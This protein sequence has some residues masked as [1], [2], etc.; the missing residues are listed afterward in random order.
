MEKLIFYTNSYDDIIESMSVISGCSVNSIKTWLKQS[1]PF[2]NTSE[3]DI[4]LNSFFKKI[5]IKFTGN[6]ELYEIIK[7]NSCVISH[8]TTRIRQPD[9]LD[10]YCLIKA[11]SMPTDISNFLASKGLIFKKTAQGLATYYENKIV[12][13][14]DYDNYSTARIKVRLRVKDK[15]IDNCING[16]LFND[17]IWKDSNVRHIKDCPEIVS[18]ICE[19]LKI[20]E[21]VHEWNNI[22]K[23]YVV[24]FLAEVKDI[25]FDKT[26]LKTTKSKIYLIYKYAI[27]YLVQCYHGIWNPIFDNQMVRLHDNCSVDKKSI[28]GFYE[29]EG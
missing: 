1:Q 3:S 12:D 19:V 21:I 13:W 22:S 17:L 18:D 11:L 27:Y 8:L 20:E 24:G 25:I 5:G 6:N 26:R 15:Y 16:F 4:K 7:F 9:K 28:V 10:I 29:I 2:I 23:P 14:N